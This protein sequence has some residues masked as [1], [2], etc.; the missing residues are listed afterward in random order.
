MF[1]AIGDM[2][3]QNVKA[4]DILMLLRKV[5]SRGVLDVARRVK[6]RIVAIFRYA[7]CI[8][9]V[10]HNPADALQ[11]VLK[12]R[13][14]VHRATLA[15]ELI[16]DFLEKL[17]RYKGHE[18]TKLGLKLIILTFVR[19][20]ELRSAEWSE[21][22][23]D[24]AEWRIPAERMKMKEEHIV[25]LSHQAIEVIQQ[26]SK[27]TRKYKL[28]FP[29]TQNVKRPMSENTLTYAIRKRLGFDATAHGFRATASTVLNEAN[30]R[31]DVIEKQLAHSVR[32]KS[33]A[34]YNRSLYLDDRKDMMQWWA[35]YLDK[36][37]QGNVLRRS[38]SMK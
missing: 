15:A 13:K 10:E 27:L 2:P 25:P 19:P 26:I 11:G 38:L 28:M 22:N 24:K 14:V 29:G 1:K 34:P 31:C 3:M 32:N 4:Q 35:D 12:T 18:L 30:F 36:Q 7:I 6:Q 23:F 5:E 37:Q 33:R 9:R 20:G 16:P 8:G 17:D 21:F